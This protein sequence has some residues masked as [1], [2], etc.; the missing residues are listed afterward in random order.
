MSESKSWRE[1]LRLRG[2]DSAATAAA[3]TQPTCLPDRDAPRYPIHGIEGKRGCIR[4]GMT[5]PDRRPR[6]LLS[7]SSPTSGRSPVA[8]LGRRSEISGDARRR[9]DRSYSAGCS[10]RGLA[11]SAFLTPRRRLLD[12]LNAECHS[13]TLAALN[14]YADKPAENALS[15]TLGTK[16][17]SVLNQR[18]SG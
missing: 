7:A 2:T 11:R 9:I 4:G 10:E 12:R 18:D 1:C 13:Y 5:P 3:T 16:P 8:S 14:G 17:D 15:Q 6:L